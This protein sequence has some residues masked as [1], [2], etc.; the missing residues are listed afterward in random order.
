MANGMN[1]A[2]IAALTSNSMDAGQVMIL[3]AVFIVLLAP[4]IEHALDIIVT[5][6]WPALTYLV[7]RAFAIIADKIIENLLIL[8]LLWLAGIPALEC[9]ADPILSLFK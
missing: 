7:R 8:V 5:F 9:F 6:I 1:D 3:V 2:A 4:V